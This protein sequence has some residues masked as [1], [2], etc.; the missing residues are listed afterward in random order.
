MWMTLS[1]FAGFFAAMGEAG[2]GR[3]ELDPRFVSKLS[4]FNLTFP[5]DDTTKHIYGSILAGHTEKFVEQIRTIV[6]V[7]VEATL[8]L[9]KV[10]HIP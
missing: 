9:Y 7:I 6:P 2:G 4:I 5:S 1:S 3:N 8:S 10:R